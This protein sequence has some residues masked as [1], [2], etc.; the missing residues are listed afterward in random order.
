MLFLLSIVYQNSKNENHILTMKLAS[1]QPY[2]FPYIGYFS[3][4]SAVDKFV[5]FDI[6]QFMRKSWMIR[7]RILKP[8]YNWQYFN[9]G[10]QYLPHKAMLLECKLAEGLAWKN[11]I[12]SQLEHYK[13]KAKFYTE[14]M[15]FVSEILYEKE[16]NLADFNVNSTIA[17]ANKLNIDTVIHRYSELTQQV[18]KADR[19]N[20]WGLNFCKAL[21]ADIYINAPGGESL[22]IEK[23]YS[24]A[25]IKLGFI[26]HKLTRYSQ[27]NENFIPGL[28]IIDVL[29]FN[30]FTKTRK[31]LKDYSI[32]WANN[33]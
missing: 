4:I 5:F 12:W 27:N 26:K 6:S 18:E 14:T 29:M 23:D 30:G 31:L 1:H 2:F 3:L 21:G 10:I 24:E 8:D 22:Y 20:L 17:I 13:K 15:S 33:K 19:G 9:A 32:K 11:K 16:T 25:G 28:S 7:N